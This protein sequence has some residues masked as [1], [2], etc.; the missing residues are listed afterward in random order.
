M[1]GYGNG[2]KYMSKFG[3][4]KLGMGILVFGMAVCCFIR[5]RL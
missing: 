5:Q 3:L 4:R 2:G 1:Q